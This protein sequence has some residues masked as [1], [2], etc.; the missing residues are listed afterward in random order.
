MN[1]PAAIITG[2][3]TGIGKALSIKLSDRY[4]IYLISRDIVKLQDV[5][6]EISAK[7]NKC[8]PIVADVSKQKSILTVYDQIDNKENI[9]LLINNAGIAVFGNISNLSFDDWDKQLNT[10]LRGCFLMTKMI[11]D[12]LKSKKNGT[13]VFINSVAGLHPYKNS[14]AYVASKYGLRGFSSS[15]REEL[16]E[17]NIKVISVYPGAVDTPLWDSMSMDDLRSEMMSVDDV[18]EVIINSIISPSN[19]V[20]EDITIRRVAGDF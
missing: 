8:Q 16:R 6:D 2:A 3:S 15:L 18:S 17:Y 12:D 9:E 13:I 20:V 10:N 5:V 4:F 1:R 7:G 19:C 14:T 11:I